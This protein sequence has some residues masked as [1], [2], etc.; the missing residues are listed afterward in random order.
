[1]SAFGDIFEALESMSLLQ[2]L[3]AFIAC[4]GYQL[5]QGLLLT[6]RGRLLAASAALAG[7]AGFALQVADWTHAAMLIA[8]GVAGMGVFGLAVLLTSRLLGV[9]R[10]ADANALAVSM[11]APVEAAPAEVPQVRLNRPLPS[12]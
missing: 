4:I 1:M 5:A 11:A 2:L 6:A 3:L 10:E 7:G 12:A 9:D 8:F